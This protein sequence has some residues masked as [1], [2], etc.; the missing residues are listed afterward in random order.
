MEYINL[1]KL[2]Q[3]YATATVNQTIKATNRKKSNINHVDVQNNLVLTMERQNS[4]NL[5]SVNLVLSA[6]YSTSN[7]ATS[8][9]HFVFLNQSLPLAS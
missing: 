5:F 3:R 1:L 9:S 7:T 2:F 8:I 6:C 4:V